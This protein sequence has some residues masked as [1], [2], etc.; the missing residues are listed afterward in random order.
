MT[1][2]TARSSV[3]ATS[4]VHVIG[5]LDA[6]PRNL[7]VP[8][9]TRQRGWRWS[10]GERGGEGCLRSMTPHEL[11]GAQQQELQRSGIVFDPVDGKATHTL[12]PT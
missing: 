12:S 8:P 7:S 10:D 9:K 4:S 11:G 3:L 2:S 6:Y 5:R 1:G